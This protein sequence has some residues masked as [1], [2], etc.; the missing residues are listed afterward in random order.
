MV[1]PPPGES[2][3]GHNAYVFYG[4][5]QAR[6]HDE[7]FGDL[8]RDAANLVLEALPRPGT[9]V[10]L[11]CGSGIFARAMIDAG[12][13]VVGVDVSP[14]MV[15]LAQRAAPEGRFSVGSVHDFELPNAVAVA[16][17]GE[18][19]N[20]ATDDRAGLEAL[21]ALAAR[22]YD[23]LVPGGV[24]VFDVSTPGRGGPEG[25]RDRFHD[26]EDW[27]LGM[28]SVE[29]DGT[30][31]REIT[32]FVRE[33][34]TYRRVDERHVLRLYPEAEV[35]DALEAAG[36]SV[37]VRGGYAD[38]AEFPGWRVYVARRL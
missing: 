36:F 27:S 6:I 32:I 14:A 10:D 17:L 21:R 28:H 4:S 3:P 19:L 30:L 18:V 8:A 31:V 37:K 25:T 13:A 29:H 26:A 15:S 5:D 23:A 35:V 2:V 38:P 11:G 1:P 16:A 9:V 34:E 20:Y 7:R 33:G 24:F 22:V 12:C